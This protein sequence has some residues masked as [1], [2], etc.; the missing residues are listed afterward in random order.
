[1][2]NQ[3]KISTGRWKNSFC[4][5]TCTAREKEK[6][7]HIMYSPYI[8]HQVTAGIIPKAI[9]RFKY[10]RQFCNHSGAKSD[11]LFQMPRHP[12]EI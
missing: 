11:R 1:M 2:Y 3:T 12:C 5:L 8:S 9:R 4:E 6:I 10:S 7:K